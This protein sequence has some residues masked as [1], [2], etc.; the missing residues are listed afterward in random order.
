MEKLKFKTV[1]Y[2]QAKISEYEVCGKGLREKAKRESNEQYGKD[3]CYQHIYE[4]RR[5]YEK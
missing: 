4:L 1:A 5:S 3:L 2:C